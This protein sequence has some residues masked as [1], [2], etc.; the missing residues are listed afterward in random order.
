MPL[1]TNNGL[2]RSDQQRRSARSVLGNLANAVGVRL[3]AGRDHVSAA[4]EKAASADPGPVKAKHLKVLCKELQDITGDAARVSVEDVMLKLHA[5]TDWQ[6]DVVVALK[7][8]MCIWLLSDRCFP[9]M[10][11]N[12]DAPLIVLRDIQDQWAANN[13][14][15]EQFSRWLGDRLRLCR[16]FPA[17]S[18]LVFHRN[19]VSALQIESYCKQSDRLAA[20]QLQQQSLVNFLSTAIAMHYD[21]LAL[22]RN[23]VS[24]SY[25][26]GGIDSR[27]AATLSEASR[28]V[29]EDAQTRAYSLSCLLNAAEQ[30]DRDGRVTNVV[31]LRDQFDRLNQELQRR[32]RQQQDAVSGYGKSCELFDDSRI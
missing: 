30:G 13:Q 23:N 4:V 11:C 29:L 2:L 5:L 26:G 32:Q 8:L 9:A 18:E 10:Q 16:D 12:L 7:V 22:L 27:L 31:L 6:S 17:L 19:V 1:E 25:N 28:L 15:V 20:Q 21:A 14:F 24:N 3:L